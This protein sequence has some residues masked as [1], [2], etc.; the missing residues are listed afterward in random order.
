[1]STSI[2]LT[3][4]L[5]L[6]TDT[7]LSLAHE[8]STLKT[9]NGVKVNEWQVSELSSNKLRF[10]CFRKLYFFFQMRWNANRDRRRAEESALAFE[11]FD[12]VFQCAE[13]PLLS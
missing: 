3:Q 4:V 10:R 1:M 6:A 2:L 5:G 8:L 7:N 11:R 12:E 9:R 13:V